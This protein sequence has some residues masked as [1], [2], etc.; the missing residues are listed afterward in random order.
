[1]RIGIVRTTAEVIEPIETEYWTSTMEWASKAREVETV[2]SYLGSAE[3][4]VLRF[5]N[6]KG[7]EIV[8]LVDSWGEPRGST[9]VV[10]PNGWGQT[11]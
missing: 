10:I 4:R 2:E 5:P 1:M 8:G 7:E 9:V 3:P 11:K 6:G